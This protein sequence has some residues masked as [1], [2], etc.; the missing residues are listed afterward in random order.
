MPLAKLNAYRWGI[1]FILQSGG[2]FNGRVYPQPSVTNAFGFEL[3][4]STLVWY[5][6]TTLGPFV[7][8]EWYGVFSAGAVLDV[9]EAIRNPG[10]R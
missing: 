10:G 1:G 8:S 2:G 9:W 6:M 3:S 4:T 7:M 5:D